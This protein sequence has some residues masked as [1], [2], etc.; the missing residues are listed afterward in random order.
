M[1]RIMEYTRY[2]ITAIVCRAY[3]NG[4][5]WPAIIDQGNKDQ[6][7]GLAMSLNYMCPG[8]IVG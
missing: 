5:H 3:V 4:H 6:V 7:Q 2:I 1:L 8:Q